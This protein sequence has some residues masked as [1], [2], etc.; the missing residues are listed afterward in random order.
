VENLQKRVVDL[1]FS[2]K[3]T[4]FKKKNR[5]KRSPEGRDIEVLKSANFQGFF[6]RTVARFVFIS[7]AFGGLIFSNKLQI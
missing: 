4:Q 5:L 6:R 2:Q 3:N 7:V 1:S